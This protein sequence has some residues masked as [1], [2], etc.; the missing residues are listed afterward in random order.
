[1]MNLYFILEDL[2]NEKENSLLMQ[3]KE[4][5]IA[6]IDDIN[7]MN[8]DLNTDL[9]TNVFSRYIPSTI[10]ELEE[11]ITDKDKIY[12]ISLS[13]NVL[14]IN[15]YKANYMNILNNIDNIKAI[16]KEQ[17]KE[18]LDKYRDLGNELIHLDYS[19]N[20]VDCIRGSVIK[21]TY[22][23]ICSDKIDDNSES[24]VDDIADIVKE[25]REDEIKKNPIRNELD[26]VN[27][28]VK[29]YLYKDGESMDTLEI[30]Q[31]TYNGIEINPNDLITKL[32]SHTMPEY[33]EQIDIRT[34]LNDTYTIKTNMGD[35]YREPKTGKIFAL[36]KEED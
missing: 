25:E 11:F 16:S 31:C 33:L 30:Q 19:T 15:N 34:T 23:S 1:M 17:V 26:M 22:Y 20:T 21:S 13:G 28:V 2:S 7:A 27:Q 9:D 6:C 29:T 4:Q 35:I 12:L 10:E 18:D 36:R 5:L 3:S 32:Y 8:S 24:I 14:Q